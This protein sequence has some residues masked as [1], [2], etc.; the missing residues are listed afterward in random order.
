MATPAKDDILASLLEEM[1][2]S[3]RSGEVGGVEKFLQRFPEYESDLRELWLTAELAEEFAKAENEQDS[4][5]AY[6]P[7]DAN[8]SIA[9][10]RERGE[11]ASDFPSFRD[12]E[13]L[14]EIGRGGMGVVYRARQKS[15]GR[16]VAIK[17]I[18]QGELASETD[19]KRFLAEA[20]SVARL[21]HPH[22]V[23][24]HEIVEEAGQLF[25]SMQ[26]IEGTT[27][28]RRIAD[29]AISGREAAR[30][31]VPIC[32]A[33]SEAHRQGV[34][35]RDLKPSNILIDQDDRPY[36]TDFG[37]AKRF[38]PPDN[39]QQ[40]GHG[41]ESGTVRTFVGPM[42]QTNAIVGT[43]GY[44]SPEQASG[45][46]QQVGVQT[47]V[48]GLGALL[49]AMVT[50]RAP[51]QAASPVNTIMM[52]L[53]QEP[54]PPR[55]LIRDLDPDLEMIVMKCLQK[56]V[57]LRYQSTDQLADDLEAYLANEPISA[58]SSRFS[59]VLGR[60]FR[61]THHAGLLENWGLLWMWHSL[62]LLILCVTT[63]AFQWWGIDSRLPYVGLWGIGLGCWAFAFWKMRRRAGP[64][65]FVERQIAHIWAGSI[66]AS[67]LLFGIE[68]IL[69]LPVL[70][71]SPVI[72]L[73]SG[74]VFL[75]KA[76]ILSGRFYCEATAL[77]LTSLL[78]AVLQRP[79][80]PDLGLTLF[81]VVS[82]SCFFFPGW[83]YYH[84]RRNR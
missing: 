39:S 61:E 71:L 16:T 40:F 32:R 18:Q 62:V 79:G 29:G 84:Q 1:L 63:N 52:V 15:L 78:M 5:D 19:R 21:Q 48:Y 53:E 70:T 7:N 37:L 67:T 41:S 25:F 55:Y 59:D 14:E 26:C 9:S 44:M 2:A 77:F 76:G 82:A 22:I 69:N 3:V 28:A 31:L 24:I 65:L 13:I 20:E 73:I 46:R 35:H 23:P 33:M 58:R 27:L 43:P 56:P 4:Q 47:D 38:S 17:M 72:G 83:K 74:T 34:L 36:V 45:Q 12:Y 51:F 6:S 60:M 64:T 57:D 81:G 54:V 66:L 10:R 8:P 49:Y 75:A 50:G 30:L 80:F 68:A 42:T 11:T